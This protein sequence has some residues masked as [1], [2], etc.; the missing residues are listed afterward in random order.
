M[1][2]YHKMT[3]SLAQ[4]E[5]DKF[6]RHCRRIGVDP[7]RK[8]GDLMRGFLVAEGVIH[9]VIKTPVR[10]RQATAA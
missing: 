5:I 10:R 8:V 7:A 9:Q 2:N 3:T 6:E 1:P 4:S